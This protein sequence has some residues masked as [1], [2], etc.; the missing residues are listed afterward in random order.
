MTITPA[1]PFSTGT[2]HWPPRL[3]RVGLV[4]GL[5]RLSSDSR[6]QRNVGPTVGPCWEV[7]GKVRRSAAKS[8]SPDPKLPEDVAPVA[9]HGPHRRVPSVVPRISKGAYSHRR[10]D[11]QTIARRGATNQPGYLFCSTTL[12]I[13]KRGT[14]PRNSAPKTSL[15]GLGMSHAQLR[16]SVR[17]VPPDIHAQADL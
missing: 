8:P 14:Y 11:S 9:R 13:L 10:T 2:A 17:K 16:I 12:S 3:R 6:P 5:G 4:W 7:W 15:A 1:C